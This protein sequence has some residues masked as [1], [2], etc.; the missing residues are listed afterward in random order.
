MKQII[1]L[2]FNKTEYLSIESGMPF[3]E[4]AA[5]CDFIQIYYRNNEKYL[6]NND[7][8][9]YSI[10]G[11]I[12]S[13]TDALNG[14]L[15]LPASISKDL[16]YL[17]NEYCNGFSSE[18]FEFRQ[19]ETYQRW[20]GIDYILWETPGSS[21]PVLAT[22]L[23]NN[24]NSEIILE[25]TPDYPWHN[26]DPEPSEKYYTYEE[27]KSAY[28]PILIR[29]IPIEVAQRWVAQATHLLGVVQNK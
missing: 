5:C 13:M 4:M 11:L 16:G 8:F 21:R 6:V 29:T 1:E 7:T 20:V 28:K 18:I 12:D 19:I 9:H 14:K 2:R 15:Q 17:W 25:I 3:Q 22:W 24:K 27:F 10:A 26:I 23:Y